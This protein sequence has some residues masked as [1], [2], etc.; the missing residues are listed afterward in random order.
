M[1]MLASVACM[2]VILSAFVFSSPAM[3]PVAEKARPVSGTEKSTASSASK[4]MS[5]VDSFGV[6][7]AGTYLVTRLPEDGPSRI[8]NIFADGNLTSI[9]STQFGGGALGG[10]WFTNQQ[11]T[12]KRLGE[13]EIAAITL[14]LAYQSKKG[15]FLGTA[16]ARYNLQFD[17]M[18]QTLAGSMQGKIFSSGIDPLNPGETKP[19]AEF[20]DSF[21]ARRV[22]FGN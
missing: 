11:G 14:D 12:W 13:F 10:D 7:I 18:L 19:V 3:E 5:E 21:E 2:G 22:T 16:I 8:L 20:S 17:D 4:A 15:K 1:R 6:Q 9:Q